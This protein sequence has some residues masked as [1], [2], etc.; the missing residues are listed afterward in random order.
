ML[1]LL[2]RRTVGRGKHVLLRLL[3]LCRWKLS[4]LRGA[5]KGSGRS[6]GGRLRRDRCVIPRGMLALGRVL[7]EQMRH[8]LGL[9]VC[10]FVWSGSVITGRFVSFFF[11]S[12]GRLFVLWICCCAR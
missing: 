4:W 6:A 9:C 3:L 8:G 1:S 5:E 12:L 10:V 7:L 11:L 2:R